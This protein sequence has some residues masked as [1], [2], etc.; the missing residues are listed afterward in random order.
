MEDILDKML[1]GRDDAS[2]LSD[3]DVFSNVK[4]CYYHYYFLYI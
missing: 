2:V 1:K 3:K 4:R